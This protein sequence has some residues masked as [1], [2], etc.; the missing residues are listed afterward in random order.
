MYLS[1]KDG[2]AAASTRSGPG[3]PNQEVDVNESSAPHVHPSIEEHDDTVEAH[4]AGL[5]RPH[6]CNDGWITLGQLVVDPETG[7][8][9]EEFALYLCR[10]CVDSR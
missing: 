3:Q 10:R 8:V 2:P 1:D 7:E 6:A 4:F 9:T 5:E